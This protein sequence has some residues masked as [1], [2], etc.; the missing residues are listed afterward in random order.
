MGR[1]PEHLASNG[2]TEALQASGFDTDLRTVE[3]E[4]CFRPEVSA[5][6]ELDGLISREVVSSMAENRFPLV[7]SGN[8]NSC[9]GTLAGMGGQAPGVVWFDG[10]ADFH[11][12]ETTTSGFTDCMGLSIIAGHC[13]KRM[14]ARVNGHKPVPERNVILA[15]AREIEPGEKER[16]LAS[17]VSVIGPEV[18]RNGDL[19]GGLEPALA[20]LRE[21]V[22]RVY[23]HLDLDVLDP[24]CV[25]R[26]NEFA[27]ENGITVEEAEQAIRLVRKHV[28]IAAAGIASYDPATDHSGAVLRACVTLAERLFD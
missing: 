2:L 13:W 14:A 22:R 28:E 18:S 16:L 9:V 8:C 3:P 25:G 6:F 26:A 12:P 15:G 7:L 17:E 24:E 5:A 11:T 23:L 27:P 21:R 1:G 20:G 19:L 10:H 4:S